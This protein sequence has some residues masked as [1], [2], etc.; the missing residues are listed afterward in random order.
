MPYSRR[1]MGS[2]LRGV[3][4]TEA[5]S[6]ASQRGRYLDIGLLTR[7][8]R[9]AIIHAPAPSAFAPDARAT[10]CSLEAQGPSASAPSGAGFEGRGDSLRLAHSKSGSRKSGATHP[11][12]LSYRQCATGPPALEPEL[13]RPAAIARRLGPDAVHNGLL[14][15]AD[16]LS[17]PEL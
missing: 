6:I 11:P 2:A 14:A 5:A 17:S 4:R 9:E 10:A 15:E 7:D 16:P 3:N 1:V 13:V 8:L 12:A